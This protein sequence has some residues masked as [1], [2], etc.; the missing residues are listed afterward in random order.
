[1]ALT[2]GLGL[3]V[4]TVNTFVRDVAQVLGMALTGWFYL[5]PVVYPLAQV[6][7][8]WRRLLELNPVDRSRP[9]LPRRF[10]GRRAAFVERPRA[11][12]WPPRRWRSS[13][14]SAVFRRASKA[15]FADEL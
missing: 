7:E 2:L 5:T 14:A 6:P 13:S 10:P 1:M 9:A 3:L 12:A 11:P 4:A 15:H 8:K